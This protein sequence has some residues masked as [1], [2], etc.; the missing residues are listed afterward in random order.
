M[1]AT[2]TYLEQLQAAHGGASD[3]RAAKILG[4]THQTV[5]KWRNRGTQM[6]DETALKVAQLLGLPPIRII[7]SI[8]AEQAK[9]E[10]ER[11]FWQQL[12]NQG[13]STH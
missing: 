13:E 5:S 12:S 9:T 8:H 6:K 4:I 2:V 3:Y 11:I 7:A 1:N 10:A